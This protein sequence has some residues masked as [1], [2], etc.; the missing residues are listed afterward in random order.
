MDAINMEQMPWT[1]E[2]VKQGKLSD[3]FA[4]CLRAMG[5]PPEGGK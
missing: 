4:A 3:V 5:D 1:G 2:E